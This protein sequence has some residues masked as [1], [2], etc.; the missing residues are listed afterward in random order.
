MDY[1]V[2]KT[3]KPFPYVPSDIDLLFFS[4]DESRKALALFARKGFRV[5]G[6]GPLNFTV[7]NSENGIKVDLY[8]EVMVSGTAYLDK[9]KLKEFVTE[10]LINGFQVPVFAPEVELLC[11][12]AHSFYKEQLYTL[13]DFYTVLTNVTRFTSKQRDV[14]LKLAKTQC[15]QYACSLS[16]ELTYLIHSKAFDERVREIEDIWKELCVESLFVSYARKKLKG[17]ERRLKMPYKYDY[18]TVILGFLEKIVK[19][20]GTRSTLP[21]QLRDLL[22][23]P[24]FSTGFIQNL[25]NH[26]LR[27]TY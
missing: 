18:V 23:N 13:A 20:N 21:N 1:V 17:K 5:L 22:L 19:D 2:F 7:L 8:D 6:S 10:T 26:A 15:V 25:V 27:E 9:R 24:T 14:F 16:L 11:T 4:R 12:I 3:L